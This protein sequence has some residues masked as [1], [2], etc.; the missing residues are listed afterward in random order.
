MIS[1]YLSPEHSISYNLLSSNYTE[2]YL[3]FIFNT[4]TL[5]KKPISLGQRYPKESLRTFPSFFKIPLQ[6]SK[7]LPAI[8]LRSCDEVRNELN[9]L[10]GD[11]F[12]DL[13]DILIEC[14]SVFIKKKLK[15]MV[16]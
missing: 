2:S 10:R 16:L 8:G 11:G 6:L 15:N 9:S 3:L 4:I 13:I 12:D 5:S 7:L 1:F 14:E